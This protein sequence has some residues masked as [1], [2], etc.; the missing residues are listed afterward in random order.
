MT[1]ME[2]L[3]TLFKLDKNDGYSIRL[4]ILPPK[5]EKGEEQQEFVIKPEDINE[6]NIAWTIKRMRRFLATYKT[7][8]LT[9]GITKNKT[10]HT[11][12]VV[13]RE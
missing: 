2:D 13:S 5:G 9:G 1:H 10:R 4:E 6:D 3:A 12:E 8:P 11:K 7:K